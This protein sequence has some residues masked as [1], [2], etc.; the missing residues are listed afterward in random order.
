[1]MAFKLSIII[2]KAPPPSPQSHNL[3]NNHCFMNRSQIS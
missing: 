2:L 1:M 3:P